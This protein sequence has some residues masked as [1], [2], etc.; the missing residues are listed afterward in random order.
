[1]HHRE[2]SRRRLFGAA[3]AVGGANALSSAARAAA[4]PAP[5]PA[6]QAPA[7]K[8]L[9]NLGDVQL[10][11]WDT[12]GTGEPIVLLHPA[13]GSAN[14]WGYQ[15]PAFASA[16]YRVVAYS[17][18]G[19][20]GSGANIGTETSYATDDLD[21]VV[22]ALKLDRFHLLGTGAGGFIAPDYALSH[23]ARLLSMT[24][25]CSQ[26]GLQDPAYQAALAALTPEGFH[27]LPAGFRELGPSYRAAH[28]E[29]VAAWEALERSSL[30]GTAPVRQLARNPITPATLASIRTPALLI[31]GGADLLMPPALMEAYARR[32][33]RCETAV[34]SDAGHSAYWEQPVAFNRLV[35]GFLSRARRFD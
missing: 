21:A 7:S 2:L 27:S 11:C 9:I 18:R 16:G 12:G 31:A 5:F 17:R 4:T 14:V 3:A 22:D 20:A 15:Q 33:P 29:G 25:A 8:R 6:A 35:L 19:Y 30:A 26:G 10:Y 23:P 1:L 34:L 28:P 24:L 32:L 13:T